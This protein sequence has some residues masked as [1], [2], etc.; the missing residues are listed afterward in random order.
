MENIPNKIE[1]SEKPEGTNCPNCKSINSIIFVENEYNSVCDQ[2]GLVFNDNIQ[3]N[4]DGIEFYK[5]YGDENLIEHH[6]KRIVY[7]E[8]K[9]KKIEND[10][11]TVIPSEI[12]NYVLK[13]IPNL[14]N[15]NNISIKNF[16]HEKKKIF[17]LLANSKYNNYKHNA[18]V[19]YS[20]IKK[21]KFKLP[22]Q[23][24]EDLHF[25]FYQIFKKYEI[26]KNTYKNIPNKKKIPNIDM[27]FRYFLTLLSTKITEYNALQYIDFFPLPTCKSTIKKNNVMIK[28]I[29]KNQEL[30][31]VRDKEYIKL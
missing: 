9:I 28:N 24:K 18:S 1:L 6:Y 29:I 10:I 30:F 27:I 20:D 15:Q 23:L 12:I 7:I 11:R 22:T 19:I 2:C 4:V 17:K 5:N 13:N 21:H 14:E 8:N 25:L 31:I 16:I 26:D 3:F